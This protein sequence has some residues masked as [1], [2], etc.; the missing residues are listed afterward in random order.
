LKM[1]QDFHSPKDKMC[2]LTNGVCYQSTAGTQPMIRHTT[3]HPNYNH[4]IPESA[5]TRPVTLRFTDNAGEE[6]PPSAPLLRL[7]LAVDV[8]GAELI[9]V[10]L[11]L[12][13]AGVAGEAGPPL[14]PG[15]F[16]DWIKPGGIPPSVYDELQVVVAYVV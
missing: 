12:G 8:G 1:I 3:N 2:Y 5:I 7:A 6:G 4:N 13:P 14:P 9:V 11:E 15:L 10:E 16:A